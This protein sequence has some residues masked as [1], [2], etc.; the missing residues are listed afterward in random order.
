MQNIFKQIIWYPAHNQLVSLIKYSDFR[1]IWL[2]GII[3]FAGMWIFIAASTWIAVEES[4]ASRWPGIIAFCSLIPFLLFAPV[5]GFLADRYNRRNIILASCIGST[6]LSILITVDVLVGSLQ[7]WHLALVAFFSGVLRTMM[8]PAVHA[9]IP[10]QVEEKHVLNA[11][12]LYAATHH[13]SRFFGL[14]IGAP[15]LASGFALSLSDVNIVTGGVETVLILS[16]VLTGLSSLFAAL[17]STVSYGQIDTVDRKQQ[18]KL[19]V[20]SPNLYLLKHLRNAIDATSYFIR[21]MLAGVSFIY[22]N[23]IIAVFIILVTFHC[24]LVMSFESI[25]P[26]FSREFLG[27]TDGSTLGYLS[28]SIG[29]G[30]I[31]GILLVSGVTKQHH[32]GYVLLLSAIGSGIAPIL[33]ALMQET[34]LAML[35]A[36][37]IGAS[38]ASFMAITHVYV[39]TLSPDRLRGRVNSLYALHAAGT[40]AFA[41]LGYGFFADIF[42]A[43]VIFIATGVIFVVFLI[44]ITASLPTLRRVYRTG[45]ATI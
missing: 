10:N 44:V 22:T 29:C 37:L 6:L 31:I 3:Q 30:A 1:N 20:Y 17:C 45:E 28:M 7:L 13:G 15:L 41:N 24:A 35:F 2:A 34:A 25:M 12:T 5:G 11:I 9:L 26:I 23:L 4:G 8:D 42:N 19:D 21:G 40:M 14:L 38:T 32:R 33:M 16:A 43:R 18:L 36:G 27:A 39:I